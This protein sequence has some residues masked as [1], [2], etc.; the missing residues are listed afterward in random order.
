MRLYLEE[1]VK[2]LYER[3]QQ[4]ALD[5]ADRMARERIEKKEQAKVRYQEF[6]SIIKNPGTQNSYG[7]HVPLDVAH[8]VVECLA[9]SYERD[10]DE[11][12]G[13]GVRNV[14]VVTRDLVNLSLT[15]KDFNQAVQKNGF[16]RLVSLIPDT[17]KLPE[18]GTGMWDRFIRKPTT[19]NLVACQ[20]A[21]RMLLKTLPYPKEM[22]IGGTKPELVLRILNIAFNLQQPLS[23]SSSIPAAILFAFH[24][25]TRQQC[26]NTY[27][28]ISYM[29]HIIASAGKHY[30]CMNARR[31]KFVYAVAKDFGDI[32]TLRKIYREAR[33]LS[34]TRFV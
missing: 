28:S 11:P 19:F 17:L 32:Q 7:T 6:K 15:C 29:L 18:C 12:G 20:S 3:K 31:E 16:P 33:S 21:A 9:S 26:T 22:R 13:D 1:E 30:P 14:C 2:E 10:A 5:R 34:R 25:S 23:Q 27:T 8:L 4:D 24:K